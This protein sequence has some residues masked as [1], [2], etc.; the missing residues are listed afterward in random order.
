MMT[1]SLLFKTLIE[2]REL[3]LR[4]AIWFRRVWKECKAK[5]LRKVWTSSQEKILEIWNILTNK[6][7]LQWSTSSQRNSKERKKH[8]K[9]KQRRRGTRRK[10]SIKSISQGEDQDHDHDQYHLM[11]VDIDATSL[12]RNIGEDDHIHLN[13]QD[14]REVVIG[15]IGSGIGIDRRWIYKR[16]T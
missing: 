15:G 3:D 14:R 16:I 8:C 10:R 4:N 6:R 9:R 12:R 5:L 2:F 13:H 11:K 1:Q 7:N